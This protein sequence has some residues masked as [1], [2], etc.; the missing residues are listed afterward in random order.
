MRLHFQS[1]KWLALFLVMVYASMGQSL[2]E[3]GPQMKREAFLVLQRSCNPCHKKLNPTKVF[4]TKTMEEH[5]TLIV[6]QVFVKKRMPLGFWNKL[7][8]AD[9]ER[10]RLWLQDYLQT[11][12]DSE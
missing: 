10:L 12:I 2:P 9:R 1:L 3:N 7:E 5:A 11:E 6:E 8:A 4:D